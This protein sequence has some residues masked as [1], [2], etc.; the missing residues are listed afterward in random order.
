MIIRN[1]KQDEKSESELMRCLLL[2]YGFVVD[3]VAKCG[4]E[5]ISPEL[6]QRKDFVNVTQGIGRKKWGANHI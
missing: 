2:A 1:K 5:W 3:L 4:S 6:H